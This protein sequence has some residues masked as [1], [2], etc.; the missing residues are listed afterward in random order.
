MCIAL[1]QNWDWRSWRWIRR[2]RLRGMCPNKRDGLRPKCPYLSNPCQLT[3]RIMKLRYEE[4]AC[5]FIYL[6][7]DLISLCGLHPIAIGAL[8]MFL[9]NSGEEI[10]AQRPLPGTAPAQFPVGG[11]QRRYQLPRD[12]VDQPTARRSVLEGSGHLQS[13]WGQSHIG[14]ILAGNATPLR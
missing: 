8:R 4:I 13:G 1:S 2:T 3:D 14:R 10:R 5:N 9:H 6:D 11:H 7:L 12:S